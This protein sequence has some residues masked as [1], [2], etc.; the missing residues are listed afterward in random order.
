MSVVSAILLLVPRESSLWERRI[1]DP[2]SRREDTLASLLDHVW[3][4]NKNILLV[5][6]QKSEV[7]K[8]MEEAF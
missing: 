4:T 7:L 5:L 3:R 1:P 6:M 8:G 2:I